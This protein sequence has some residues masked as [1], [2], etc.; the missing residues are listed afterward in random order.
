MMRTV[1]FCLLVSIGRHAGDR[2]WA[3]ISVIPMRLPITYCMGY[4]RKSDIVRFGS[5][6]GTI[7]WGGAGGSSCVIDTESHVCL[8]YV[9]NQMCFDVL[10]DQ[11]ATNL[12]IALHEGL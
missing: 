10:A 8:S 9:M 11:R 4:A 6:D 1:S 7:W 5:D 3:C 2:R 12:G